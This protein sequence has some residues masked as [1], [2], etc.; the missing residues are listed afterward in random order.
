[1][2]NESK[3]G[4]IGLPAGTKIGKY[5]VKE[6]LAMGGQAIIYKAYDA[7]LDRYVAIKQISPHLAENPMFL[8]RFRK[9]AQILARLGA[10]Q[11]AIVT[12]HELIADERGL[13]IVM[14]HVTGKSLELIFEE[15]PQPVETKAALQILWRLA[16][17]LNDVHCAGIIHRDI[18]PGNIIIGEG[19]HPKIADFGVAA[20]LTGQTSMVLGTTKYM[21]PELLSGH[22]F[23]GRAD[24]YSLGFIMYEMLV[25]RA[26]FN[27]LFADIVR[28]KHSEAL[29][30]MKWHSNTSLQAPPLHEVNPAIPPMLSQIVTT[31]I[32]KDP[33]GRFADMEA[34]GKAIKVEFSPKARAT[35]SAGGSGGKHH[36]H[37][38]KAANTALTAVADNDVTGAEGDELMLSAGPATAPI[39]KKQLAL[40]TKLILAGAAA[41]LLIIAAVTFAVISGSR[42]RD[43]LQYAN[44][45]YAK[46]E[47]AYKGGKYADAAKGFAEI[48]TN[49]Y[50]KTDP[51]YKSAVMLKLAQAHLAIADKKWDEAQKRDSEASDSRIKIQKVAKGELETWSRNVEEM[52]KTAERTRNAGKAFDDAMTASR[53]AFSAGDYEKARK[54]LDDAMQ[55]VPLK[56]L[57]LQMRNLRDQINQAEFRKTVDALI[58]SGIELKGKGNAAE[59]ATQF[60]TARRMLEDDAKSA[61]MSAKDR[62]ERKA[63]I[64]KLL[65][66]MDSDKLLTDA[67]AEVAKAAEAR[68]RVAEMDAINKVLQLL[69]SSGKTDQ[70]LTNR[71]TALAAMN[72]MDEAQKDQIDGKLADAKEKYQAAKEIFAAAKD[73]ESAKNA[74]A[75]LTVVE[76]MESRVRMLLEAQEAFKAADYAKALALCEEA[77]KLTE[78]PK[79]A[80]PNKMV[81]DIIVECKYRAGM[82]K[83]AE[84][85]DAGKYE[86]AGKLLAD[87]ATSCPKYIEDINKNIAA[88]KSDNDFATAMDEADK[89]YKAR[90]YDLANKR[91]ADAKKFRPTDPKAAAMGDMILF[92]QNMASAK[93]AASSNDIPSA[94]AYA[95]TANRYAKTDEQRNAVKEFLA[96]LGG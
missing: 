20:S 2:A 91:V 78:P 64:D 30:W 62:D 36:K 41:A 48:F 47:E 80:V 31:M 45:T 11:S 81:Q 22:S 44:S 18:K 10:T 60:T 50:E 33:A 59:A 51:W 75:A 19:L 90:L 6:R 86:E 21:A 66:T 29:R 73:D 15:N 89:A 76:Q 61:R 23:D 32:C 25:G 55:G 1:M 52:I 5:E 69:A 83:A 34:L 40:R 9:E 14:E 54:T 82:V 94:K 71:K 24:M 43:R 12:I 13:F 70:E 88:V 67:R 37:K 65:Q 84:L 72:L 57:Q 93:A 39:P 63:S 58:E 17:A 56:D 8:E 74:K 68:D 79:A 85:R 53:A 42:D 35:A 26:K 96:G 38:H 3:S 95:N 7:L 87:L 16:A 28:D 49:Q 27:E 46:A 77:I 4:G 92:G